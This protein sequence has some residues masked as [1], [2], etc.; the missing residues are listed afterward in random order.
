[1]LVYRTFSIAQS[2]INN[3]IRGGVDDANTLLNAYASPLGKSTGANL[4]AGWV[5]TA[6]ALKPGRFE[7]KLIGNAA[8]VPASAR[9][10]NLDA[11]G[12]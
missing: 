11:L 4:N 5:N 7:L 1:M 10:Y 6:A 9:T 2:E 3:F 8:Y 12:F